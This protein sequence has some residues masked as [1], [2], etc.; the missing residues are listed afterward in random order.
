MSKKLYSRISLF[1]I[2]VG[3]SESSVRVSRLNRFMEE[4]R[5]AILSFMLRA[6]LWG[7]EEN[8]NQKADV[9]ANHPLP[10]TLDR[11]IDLFSRIRT[12]PDL[13]I[14]SVRNSITKRASAYRPSNRST[15]SVAK[16]SVSGWF[17]LNRHFTVYRSSIDAAKLWTEILLRMLCPTDWGSGDR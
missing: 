14:A 11:R 9:F 13:R 17:N 10:T 15:L 4:R 5:L 2:L 12:N 16:P 6:A 7:R 3:Q 8:N 1:N